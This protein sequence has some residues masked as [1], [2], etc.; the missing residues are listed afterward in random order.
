MQSKPNNEKFKLKNKSNAFHFLK[1]LECWQQR[2]HGTLWSLDMYAS[3]GQGGT[4][5]GEKG[6]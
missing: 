6:C 3:L 2:V 1:L 4:V 5:S